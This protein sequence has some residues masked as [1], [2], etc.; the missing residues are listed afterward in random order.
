MSVVKCL[1]VR[2]EENPNTEITIES[3]QN[4]SREACTR[5]SE[6]YT[7]P[8][9][10]RYEL[11]RWSVERIAVPAVR[12]RAE[13]EVIYEQVEGAD[14][15]EEEIEAVVEDR[16]RGQTVTAR[17]RIGEKEAIRQEWQ[18]GFALPVTF[19]AYGAEFYVLGDRM[20][21][22]RE[23][24]PDLDG[25]ESLLLEL[26][27]LSPEEYRITDI[28]WS[29][30]AYENA[31]GEPCRDAIA[32]GQ[33]LVRDYRVNYAGTAFFPAQTAWRT[34]AVY[35]PAGEEEQ[36]AEA[37]KPPSFLQEPALLETEAQPLETSMSLWKQITRVLKMIVAVGALLFLGG[38]FVLAAL[39][40]V[41]KL[42][43]CYN[44]R[45]N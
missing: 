43:S 8:G 20:I 6:E 9:G 17:C 4:R 35:R 14:V 3:E 29:G 39:Q 44:R 34:V 2:A 21:P 27:G 19:H 11:E 22:Y 7:D 45:K 25:G 26:A 32:S 36:T 5:P 15:L 33:K 31:E 28:R 13:Q 40:V 1:E 38:L 42:R 24:R 12:R 18:D 16:E 10:N 30:D 37:T 41:K 23:D